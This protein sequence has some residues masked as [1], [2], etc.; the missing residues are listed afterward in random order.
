LSSHS[1][2]PSCRPEWARPLIT[3]ERDA[4]RCR[5]AS[6]QIRIRAPYSFNQNFSFLAGSPRC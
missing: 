1:S 3:D 2:R 4:Y 6:V 5:S